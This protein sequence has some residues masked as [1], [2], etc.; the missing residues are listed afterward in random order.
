MSRYDTYV[1]SRFQNFILNIITAISYLKYILQQFLFRLF[2]V[3]TKTALQS[4]W[5]PY[6]CEH[7]TII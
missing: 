4:R 3:K 5:R 2:H 1:A 7:C 6:M